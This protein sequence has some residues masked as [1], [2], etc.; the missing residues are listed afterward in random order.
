MFELAGLATGLIG[1]FG[2]LFSR[3]RSNRELNRLLKMNPEYTANPEAAQRLAL[4]KQ[5]LNARSPGAVAAERN[6]YSNQANSTAAATRA[7]TD[8]SQLLA[9][10]GQIQGQTNDAFNELGMDE[11]NDYQRR[12][13][14]VSDA[15]EG[16][17]REGDK[18]YAD[19]VR[20]FQDAAQIK[21]AQMANRGN[22]WS[23]I[24]NLGFGLAD[25]GLAGGFSNYFNRRP[26]TGRTG[27]VNRDQLDAAGQ[28]PRTYRTQL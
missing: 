11:T 12:F 18:V 28:L 7:A 20:R 25:Y 17:I 15:Q 3:G 16:V 2:K 26:S 19:K 27:I 23:D 9:T 5:L 21:G 4:T 6:I 1:G 10:A 8:S 13:G 14:N 24:S 22:N